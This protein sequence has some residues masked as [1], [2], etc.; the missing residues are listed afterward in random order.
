MSHWFRELTVIGGV[1]EI[2]REVR[3]AVVDVLILAKSFILFRFSMV[4][5]FSLTQWWTSNASSCRSWTELK[6][7]VSMAFLFLSEL[8]GIFVLVIFKASS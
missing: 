5:A 3:P 2:F 6:L 7:I 4:S 1:W 8:K